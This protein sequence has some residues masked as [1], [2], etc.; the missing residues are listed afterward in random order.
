M[1]ACSILASITAS[2]ILTFTIPVFADSAPPP[3]EIVF[4]ADQAYPET[5][6]WSEKQ[7]LFFVSSVRHGTV[8]KVTP[9]GKYT[10]FITDDT[11]VSSVGLL[12]DDARNRLWVTNSDPGASD[13]TKAATQ[14]KLAAVAAYDATTGERLAYYDLGSLSA[15]A[16]FANDVVLDAQGN[17]YVSDSFAP[18][19][20]RIDTEGK[21]SI[22]ATSPLFNAGEGFKLNGISWHKDGYL[23]VGK[24]NSGELFRINIANPTQIDKVRLPEALAGI[25]GFHLIDKNHLVVVQNLGADR[26]LEL[27]S[28]DGWKSAKIVRQQKSALS[29]PSSATQVGK[30]IYVL[31]SRIDTLFDPK[32]A[33]VS[34]YLLQKF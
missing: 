12:V 1:K 27:T 29:M 20:Y 2:A 25:D 15:G 19:V 31:D 3:K 9:D 13:Q 5:A 6:S 32:A 16:H 23:L 17:L 7:H 10:P 24:Y 11:L 34:D 22:F 21:I 4:N 26:I 14:G 28:T 8:G 33:K 18:N 30:D